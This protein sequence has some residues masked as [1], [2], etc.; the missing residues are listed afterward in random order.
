M[1]G[2]I[3][4]YS[5]MNLP[6]SSTNVEKTS[7]NS[8]VRCNLCSSMRFAATPPYDG[9]LSTFYCLSEECCFKIPPHISLSEAA[10][11]EPLSISI[12]FCGLAGNL[13]GKTVAVFG[14]GPI[15][16]LCSAVASAFGASS[17]VTE[18]Y[19]QLYYI[20][21]NSKKFKP[22]ISNYYTKCTINRNS[23]EISNIVI[24]TIYLINLQEYSRDIII[25]KTKDYSIFLE[26]IKILIKISYI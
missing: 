24:P 17:V 8:G 22:K 23:I 21:K 25:T 4:S 9:T 16:L 7:R 10:L 2:T 15:G 14:A 18:D 19:K 12:H 1:Y 3:A 5:V 26:V 13:Q 6:V 11:V 20:I